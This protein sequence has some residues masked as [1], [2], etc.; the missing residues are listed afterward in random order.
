MEK[1][2]IVADRQH[3]GKVIARGLDFAR[4]MGL[5]PQVLV[6][7]WASLK[8]IEAMQAGSAAPLKKALLARHV[9][10]ARELIEKH[11]SDDANS[12]L[13]RGVWSKKPEEWLISHLQQNAADY[14]GV[15]ALVEETDSGM[16]AQR[17]WDL[18][19]RSPVRVLRVAG[20]HWKRTHSVLAA[21]DLATSSRDKLRL[22]E[23]IL[24]EAKDVAEALGA[25]L[26]VVSAVVVPQLLEDLD[27]IDL[28]S[29]ADELKRKMQPELERLC[30]KYG[31]KKSQFVLKRGEVDK[32]IVSVAADYKAQLV[33]MG[34]VGRRGL[35]AMVLGNTAEEILE[36]LHTDVLA[37]KP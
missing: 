22:N 24:A 21:V 11:C 32:I 31:L 18:L 19:R 3:S 30:E 15:V 28:N 2:L 1:L 33:V 4:Q 5:Q 23:R 27:V 35:A 14:Y 29:Y 36:H 7:T 6:F 10:H 37:L 16:L 13:V 34:T 25:D 17:N 9:D 20:E 8:G 12:V 26:N